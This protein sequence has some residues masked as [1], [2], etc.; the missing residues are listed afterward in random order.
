MSKGEYMSTQKHE[1]LHM[2]IVAQVKEI[3]NPKVRQECLE[4]LK[5]YED[6]DRFERAH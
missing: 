2:L 4:L 5:R 1:L 3:D 6:Q